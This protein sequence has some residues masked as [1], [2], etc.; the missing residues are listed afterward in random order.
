MVTLATCRYL[1]SAGNLIARLRTQGQYIG[2]A[3]LGF[4]GPA[5]NVESILRIGW[6]EA[7]I[8]RAQDAN[9]TAHIID[10]RDLFPVNSP[11]PPLYCHGRCVGLVRNRV[12]EVPGCVNGRCVRV[13]TRALELLIVLPWTAGCKTR[14]AQRPHEH[15]S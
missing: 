12:V 1:A 10:V 13:V 2:D 15:T 3:V 8:A 14:N 9:S 11:L 7:N 6:A 4:D 5:A